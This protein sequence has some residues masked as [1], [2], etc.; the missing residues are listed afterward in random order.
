MSFQREIG[1]TRK[2]VRWIAIEI[3]Y[4]A[5]IDRLQLPM[6][7]VEWV[8]KVLVIAS[9]ALRWYVILQGMG[10]NGV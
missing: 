7:A 10:E 8:R 9:D 5:L 2:E 1:I 4:H 3:F 6:N